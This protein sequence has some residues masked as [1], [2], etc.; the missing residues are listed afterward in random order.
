MTDT[1]PTIIIS[2]SRRDNVLK[3]WEII[4]AYVSGIWRIIDDSSLFRRFVLGTT[5]YLTMHSIEW[6]MTIAEKIP[7]TETAA[8]IAAVMV[9]VT[10]LQ[11]WAL[12]FYKDAR[13]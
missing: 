5:M 3:K 8:L 9:P 11:A 1:E 6:A 4:H 13:K 7:K 2:N 12:N 10:G